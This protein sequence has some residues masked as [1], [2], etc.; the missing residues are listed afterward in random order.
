MNKILLD[1]HVFLWL[2]YKPQNIS[3]AT[4]KAIQSADYVGVSAI[5]LWELAIK[6]KAGKLRFSTDDLLSGIEILGLPLL[7]CQP[8]HIATYKGI[9]LPHKDPFDAMLIA[10]AKAEGLAL[11]TA[12]NQLLNSHYNTIDA[13][14]K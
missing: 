12:D 3:K 7:L 8:K 14:P 10:Q 2:L 5:T 1:S 13:R 6:H 11:L 4:E 9:N